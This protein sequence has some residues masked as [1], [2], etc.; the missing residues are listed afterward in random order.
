MRA[1]AACDWVRV[2]GAVSR[3]G[4][5]KSGGVHMVA[6]LDLG[7][8]LQTQDGTLYIRKTKKKAK[9]ME[10]TVHTIM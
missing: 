6:S 2:H 9:T 10:D 1:W 8:A 7:L 5:V 3:C 4:V